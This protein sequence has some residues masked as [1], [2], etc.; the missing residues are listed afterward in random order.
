MTPFGATAV[1]A[2]DATAAAEA[3]ALAFASAQSSILADAINDCQSAEALLV[4]KAYAKVLMDTYSKATGS[5]IAVDA[6]CLP[7]AGLS[8]LRTTDV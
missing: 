1:G 8:M 7:Q 2:V 4:V 6:G 5:I 3:T